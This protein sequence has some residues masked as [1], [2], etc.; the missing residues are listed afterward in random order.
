LLGLLGLR[1]INRDVPLRR[2][3]KMKEKRIPK[4]DGATVDIFC[5]KKGVS[6]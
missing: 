5:V 6:N 3:Q 4:E 2:W 1:V